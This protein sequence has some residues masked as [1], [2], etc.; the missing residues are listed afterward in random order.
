MNQ[1]VQDNVVDNNKS[2]S[3]TMRLFGLIGALIGLLLGAL[4]YREYIQ[5]LEISEMLIIALLAIIGA[6]IGVMIVKL[7]SMD[8]KVKWGSEGALLGALLGVPI[9]YFFQSG[10]VRAWMSIVGYTQKYFEVL[11][12]DKTRTP[13][14]VGIIVCAIAGAIIGVA[15]AMKR[16]TPSANK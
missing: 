12:D 2:N 4:W 13:A 7:Q 1:E 10:I 8:I 6:S 11:Q 5:S 16:A 14:I 9:S 3:K 15:M